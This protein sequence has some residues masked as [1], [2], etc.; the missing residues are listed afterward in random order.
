M[1]ARVVEAPMPVILRFARCACPI[2]GFMTRVTPIH[3]VIPL[4]DVGTLTAAIHTAMSVITL[5]PPDAK[6]WQRWKESVV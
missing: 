1:D 2:S 3:S 5:L 6:W 4:T